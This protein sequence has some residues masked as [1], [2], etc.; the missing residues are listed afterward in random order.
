MWVLSAGC[1]GQDPEEECWV[2]HN[3]EMATCWEDFGPC[4]EAEIDAEEE[5]GDTE[6]CYDAL[7]TCSATT[8][9]E[10][11]A[12]ADG[13]ESC[14]AQLYTCTEACEGSEAEGCTDACWDAL[15]EC[16]DWVDPACHQ[17]CADESR[18]CYDEV[19]DRY[20]SG[21]YEDTAQMISASAGCFSGGYRCM[22][23][24]YPVDG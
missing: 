15:G 20:D 13:E 24:C 17:S 16:A 6:V 7:D 1:Q 14:V 22:A 5:G 11:Q 8:K 19:L 2:T 3:Q 23:A 10:V 4:M 9:T 18:S 12:C 21:G